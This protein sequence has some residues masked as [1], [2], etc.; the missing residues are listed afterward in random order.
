MSLNSV[1]CNNS[2]TKAAH[3]TRPR[4]ARPQQHQNGVRFRALRIA[5]VLPAPAREIGA[6][7][8]VQTDLYVTS[9]AGNSEGKRRQFELNVSTPVE[10]EVE[11][12]A[13][14]G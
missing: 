2:P 4:F 10:A 7:R 13:G 9:S 8:G 6:T 12:G 14:V 5:T 1:C 11:D 3:H